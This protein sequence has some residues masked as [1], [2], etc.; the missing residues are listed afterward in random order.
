MLKRPRSP[1]FAFLEPSYQAFKN[2]YASRTR[3]MYA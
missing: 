3:M 2:V 1:V